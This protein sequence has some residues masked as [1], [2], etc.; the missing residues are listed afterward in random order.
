M[1]KKILRC[2]IN[3]TFR[4]IQAIKTLRLRRVTLFLK[5]K[6]NMQNIVIAVDGHSSCG[7]STLAKA[8]AKELGL[9]YIDT[10]AMYRGATFMAMENALIQGDRVDEEKL[11]AMLKNST[12]TFKNFEGTNLLFLNERNIE[13]EIRTIEVSDKVSY[14]SKIA[15][16]RTILVD[17]QRAMGKSMN[18]ILDGR[19]I[20]TVVFP[21]ADVKLFVTASVETRAKR[22]FDELKM[23]GEN[24][25]FEEVA[26]NI[27]KR[28]FIDQNRE[29]SPLK[30]AEDA[31]V[32]DNSF[33]TKQEQLE[34][35]IEIITTKRPDIFRQL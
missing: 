31:V 8:V 26:N 34:A 35:A 19:D 29:T 9:V 20:G 5:Q 6:Q 2:A 1:Q 14:V 17:W 32:I 7:K 12:M 16:V 18:V 11:V 30:Q 15:T 13:R 4:N 27:Q 28:D 3:D 24:V 22:R 33:L 10:G 23:M 21:H 25:T